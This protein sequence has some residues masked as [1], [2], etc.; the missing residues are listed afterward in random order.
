MNTIDTD[1]VYFPIRSMGAG[2]CRQPCGALVIYDNI[3]TTS[4]VSSSNQ[5]PE[6]LNTYSSL[7]SFPL[8]YQVL[9]FLFT[10]IYIYI[11]I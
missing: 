8:L 10:Y 11:Y 4:A 6:T 1:D 3:V 9:L 5:I 2:E 7:L